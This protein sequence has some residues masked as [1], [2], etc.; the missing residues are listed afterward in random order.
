MEYGNYMG[1]YM[2][3]QRL[4]KVAVA[5]TTK[6]S[7]YDAISVMAPTLTVAEQF[8]SSNGVPISEDKGDFWSK[9]YPNRYDFTIIP[10]EGNNKHYLKNR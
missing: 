9:N 7:H 6:G 5:K 1:K 10:D 8:Y 2:E 3:R 4:Q